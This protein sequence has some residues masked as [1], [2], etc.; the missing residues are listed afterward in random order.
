MDLSMDLTPMFTQAAFIFNNMLQSL[1][2]TIGV[3][4]GLGLVG[5]VY[6][7]IVKKF[8]TW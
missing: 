2:F 7:A 6:K 1:S 5:W 8:I 3:M 4:L